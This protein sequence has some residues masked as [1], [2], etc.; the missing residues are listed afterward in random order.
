MKMD[1]EALGGYF[2]EKFREMVIEPLSLEQFDN[3]S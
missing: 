1:L 2:G 3:S